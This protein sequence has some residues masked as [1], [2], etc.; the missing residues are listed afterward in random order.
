MTFFRTIGGAFG[1]SVFGAI[2]TNSL[3]SQLRTALAGKKLPPGFDIASR[4]VELDRAQGAA[5]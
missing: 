1:V 5:R 4:T 2:F 3:A